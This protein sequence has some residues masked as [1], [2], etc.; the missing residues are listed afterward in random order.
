[1]KSEN[2]LMSYL[3]EN[4]EEGLRLTLKTDPEVVK[5]QAAWAGLKPGMR[6]LDVGCGN[7]ITTAALAEV[8]GPSGHATGLDFSDERLTEA[9][10]KHASEQI[11]FVRHDINK[12]YLPEEPFDF[13]WLRFFLEYFRKEQKAVVANSAAAL[14]VGGI[15]CLADLDNNSLTHAGPL[16][17]DRLRST[18][19]D[20]MARLTRDFNFDP[21]AGQ[22]LYGHLDSLDF[23]NIDC[24]VEPHHL[25]YGKV[26]E[27]ALYNWIRKLELT[28]IKSGCQFEAYM[29]EEFAHYD[30]PY[31]AL[32]DEFR[33][34]IND[35]GRFC[36][37][38]I[39]ICRGEK[40]PPN[41]R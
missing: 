32:M 19:Q 41:Q 16:Y 4:S 15:A 33:I 38:P 5:R 9:R 2:K 40:T 17:T 22:R 37:T 7:G 29:G 35:P 34:Y 13:I 6:V 18:I 1:M 28:A 26:P 8:V 36:Y 30:N 25:V 11:D 39:I 23:S 3:M 20:I 10:D 12:P 14:K 31:E 21:F 27:E 24:M